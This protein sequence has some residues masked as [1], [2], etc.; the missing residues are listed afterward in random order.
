MKIMV[1]ECLRVSEYI[2]HWGICEVYLI[3]MYWDCWVSS[4]VYGSRLAGVRLVI[5]LKTRAIIRVSDREVSSG[6]VSMQKR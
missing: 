6:A 2:N 4:R 5:A 1:F 3:K